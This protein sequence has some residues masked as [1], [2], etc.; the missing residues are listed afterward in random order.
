VKAAPAAALDAVSAETRQ[1]YVRRAQVWTPIDT[2]SLDLMAGP[3]GRVPRAFDSLVECNF[4]DD[5]GRLNGVTPKFLCRAGDDVLKV[6]YGDD[7]GEVYA[8]VVATRLFWALGFG[9]DRVYPVQV[10]CHDCPMDPWLWRTSVRFAER[11]FVHAT[12]EEK[13][14]GETITVRDDV[15]WSWP[16]LDEVDPEAGGAPVAHRDALKL[17]AVFVQHGDNKRDQQRLVCRPEGVMHTSEGVTCSQPFL[18]ISDLGATFG[19]AGKLSRDRTAK[20]NYRLWSTKP[21]F[22][23]GRG[24]VGDLN[25]SMRGSLKNPTIGEAGRRFLAERLAALSDGQIHDLFRAGRV[26]ERGETVGDGAERRRVTVDDWVAA[27]K[28]R[29]RQIV[30]RHCDE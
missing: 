27:F 21:V 24:C 2:A 23:A 10:K 6:K 18:M 25:A 3:R 8:E 28:A 15:G 5:Q 1:A 11:L 4:V 9:A 7:N 17:L 16:E 12:V 30:E 13:F 29:R 20:L 26:D 14:E 22:R 19:G